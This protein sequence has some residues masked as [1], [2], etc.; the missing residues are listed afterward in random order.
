MLSPGEYLQAFWADLRGMTIFWFAIGLS[1]IALDLLVGQKLG[2]RWQRIPLMAGLAALVVG[3]GGG[4]LQT[5]VLPG[6]QIILWLLLAGALS[7]WVRPLLSLAPGKAIA[8]ATEGKV[9][10]AIEPGQTG[11]VLYEGSSW[12]AR[13]I[14]PSVQIQA[15]QQVYVIRREGTTLLVMPTDFAER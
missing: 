7:L 13:C 1:L 10:T 4:T 2:R 15:Q 3:L 9:L 14:D 8:D 5:Y 11:R 6:Y 12:Q